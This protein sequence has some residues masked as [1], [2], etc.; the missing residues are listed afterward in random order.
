MDLKDKGQISIFFSTTVIVM[1][2]FMAFIVNIGMFVKAKINLQNATDAAAYAGAS[3]QARQLTNIAYMNWELR[4]IYKEWM[5]KYYVIGSLN[6]NGVLNPIGGTMNFTMASFNRTVTTAIDEYNFP[7]TCVDFSSSGGVG[8]CTKYLVPG[9]PR[10]EASNVLGMDETTNAFVDSIVAEKADDCSLRTKLNFL[11][12]N[13]WAYNVKTDNDSLKNIK[14]EAPE[15]GPDR[16]GA[17]PQAIEVAFRIRN[18]EAQVN[19]PPLNNVC[20]RTSDG[21]DCSIP[22]DELN[23][24]SKERTLKALLSGWRN[25]GTSDDNRMKNSFTIKEVSPRLDTSFKTANN[26]STLLIPSGSPALDKYYLDL[27]LMTVNYAPFYTAFAPTTSGKNDAGGINTSLGIVRSEGQCAATKIG[28]P[29]PGYPLGFVKNPDLLTYYA[30]ESKVKF[31]GLFN[32]FDVGD[33]T[34]SAYAAAKPFGGRIGPMLFDVKDGVRVKSRSNRLSSAYISGLNISEFKDTFGRSVSAGSYAPGMPVPVNINESAGRFW[35]KSASDAVGG[36]VP[37]QEIFFGIPNI[38]WDYPSGSPGN[39]QSYYAGESH[40][41]QEIGLIT[42]GVTPQAGL[43]NRDMFNRFK[44]HLAG[45][46]G[47]VTPS[48]ID[49]ALSIVRAPTLYEA[50]NYLIPTPEDLN[51]KL[52]TDSWGKITGEQIRNPINSGS[53]KSF[54]IY[55]FKLYAPIFSSDKSVAIYSSSE[56]LVQELDKYLLYQEEA[57]KKYKTSMN[58]VA[59]DI[60]NN[61]ESGETGQNTGKQAA[62]QISDLT[63]TEYNAIKNAVTNAEVA[64]P[65]CASITGKFLYF[66]LGTLTNEVDTSTNSEQCVT[67]LRELLRERWASGKLTGDLYQEFSY[68]IPDNLKEELFTAYRP[69]PDHD[70]GISDGIQVNKLTGRPDKMIRNFYST[71]FIPMKS[72]TNSDDS[73][74][75]IGT[76]PIYSEGENDESESSP[77]TARQNFKNPIEESSLKKSKDELYH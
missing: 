19:Q 36:I 73:G 33:I 29:V 49:D 53:G 65:S 7:S 28:L 50:Q 40:E 34:L 68:A 10:F 39:N 52:Q 11:T 60:Y 71:K 59:A 23:S 66:Y 48:D 6:I 55:N 4:N 69:G 70:A 25:L 13:T 30:I 76:M 35:L 43:Y 26:L 15:I 64:R 74:Y 20:M 9:L 45:L 75:R 61:N 2:T 27:K 72:L 38:L 67:P 3:V 8:L 32:P 46:G 1:I 51:N 44:D 31:N 77:E 63:A 24:P 56:D 41:V 42:G 12:A 17:F 18:L 16:M 5:F 37:Q 47:S 14:D 62:A 22:I 21:V 54:S 57:L 58:I